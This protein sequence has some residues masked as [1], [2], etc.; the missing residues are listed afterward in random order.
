MEPTEFAIALKCSF[1]RFAILLSPEVAPTVRGK[2]SFLGF[3]A[4]IFPFEVLIALTENEVDPH[5]LSKI[6]FH[7]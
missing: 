7:A 1:H 4:L 6:S 3:S 2:D 5:S